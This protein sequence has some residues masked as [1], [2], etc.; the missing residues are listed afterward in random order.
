MIPKTAQC[1]CPLAPSVGQGQISFLIPSL[2][3]ACLRG[4]LDIHSA[5][6]RPD[7][8]LPRGLRIYTDN[9]NCHARSPSGAVRALP[10]RPEGPMRPPRAPCT[11]R[12]RSLLPLSNDRISKCDAFAYR[13]DSVPALGVRGGGRSPWRS[14]ALGRHGRLPV[15]AGALARRVSDGDGRKVGV[16]GER[17]AQSTRWR[18]GGASEY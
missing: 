11:P 18:E 8:N 1:L 5:D 16:T 17:C 10:G 6:P 4:L 15:A 7:M 2:V 13:Y 12:R 3:S 9:C 14:A